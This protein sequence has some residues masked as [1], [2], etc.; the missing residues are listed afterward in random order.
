MI[1]IVVF[2]AFVRD[3][4]PHEIL[5]AQALEI[6]EKLESSNCRRGL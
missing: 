3:I 5:F 4:R 2:M 1:Q 6:A